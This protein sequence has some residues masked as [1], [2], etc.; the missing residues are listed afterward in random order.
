METL[1][2]AKWSE[3]LNAWR[4]LYHQQPEDG[5]NCDRN[6]ADLSGKI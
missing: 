4:Y 3:H 6:Q 5:M 2:P 1:Y